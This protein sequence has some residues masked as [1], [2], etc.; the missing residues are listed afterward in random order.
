M[1]VAEKQFY[2]YALKDLAEFSKYIYL[3]SSEV[4]QSKS[5]G[6]RDLPHQ[7]YIDGVRSGPS[8]NENNWLHENHHLLKLSLI[9][10]RKYMLRA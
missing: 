7:A 6:F 10:Y 5:Q 2:L 1:G 9:E 4:Q 3:M 8:V